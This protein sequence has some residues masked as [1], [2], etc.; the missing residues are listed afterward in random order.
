MAKLIYVALTSL[1]GYVA[2]ENG[3]FQFARPNP[4]AMTITNDLERRCR[5]GLYG[6]RMYEVMLFWETYDDGDEDPFSR[7]FAR[8]WRSS[9]KVVYSTTLPHVS[10]T[11]TR[12]ERTFDPAAIREM[13]RSSTDDLTISGP[14]LAAEAFE[15]GLVD[16]MHLFVNPVTIGGG[17]RA[18]AESVRSELE[19]VDQRALD[20]GVVYLHYRVVH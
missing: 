6:R 13:K 3:D 17:T 7:D 18:Y 9:T 14:N 12:L 19:L 5:T 16:E 15:A 20:G 2:D 4:D 10:S 8:L 11:H 1:D